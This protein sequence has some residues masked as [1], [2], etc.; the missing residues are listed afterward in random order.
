M[1]FVTNRSRWCNQN[2]LNKS[3]NNTFRNKYQCLLKGGI[4]PTQI[5]IKI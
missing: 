3:I 1:K 2:N 4:V 5:K